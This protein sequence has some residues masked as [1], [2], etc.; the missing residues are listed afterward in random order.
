[1]RLLLT[2][3]LSA[4]LLGCAAEQ[5]TPSD[6]A[7]E[8]Q[9][10]RK[11][12]AAKDPQD[13]GTFH[14]YFTENSLSTSANLVGV[15]DIKAGQQIHPPH[16]HSDEEYLMVT[17]GRGTWHLNGETMP[18]QKGDI[19]YAKPWDYHGIKAAPGSDLQFVVFK[20]SGKGV[21]IPDPDPSLAEELAE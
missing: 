6:D 11:S 12:D 1:M 16:R 2:A 20:W 10:I 19:L 3:L 9:I 17:K 8:S 15:A 4:G 18:A 5:A 7:M 13:W 21:N 14:A